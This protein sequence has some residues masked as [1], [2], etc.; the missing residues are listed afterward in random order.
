MTVTDM[1]VSPVYNSA[2]F[3]SFESFSQNNVTVHD[4]HTSTVA[5]F[6][7]SKIL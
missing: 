5:V 7:D 1:A 4:Q 3:A 2:Q 6:Q